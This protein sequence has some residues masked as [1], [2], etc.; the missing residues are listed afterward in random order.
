MPAENCTP[1]GG[2]PG[3][4]HERLP[5]FRLEF[6]PS[7][8][9]ELQSEYFVD[10]SHAVPAL[11]AITAVR[12]VVAPVLQISELR[13]VAADDL[14]LSPASG[15]DSVA[16][17]F[18]WVA[19]AAAVAPAVAA[20]ERALAPFGARPH[21]GKVFTTAPDAV[22]GLYERFDDFAKLRQSLDPDGVFANAL[23]DRYLGP[24]GG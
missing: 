8:G 3:P 19:D 4:W 1:Q 6:T 12:H 13:T 5:H 10:R 2:V 23:T 14:W 11:E 22:R 21:W 24:T 16:F 9:E 17:H 20:I 7:S 18:T 15:R